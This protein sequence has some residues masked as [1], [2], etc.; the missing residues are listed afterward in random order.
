MLITK[1]MLFILFLSIINVIK[2]VF[3]FC[4]CFKYRKEYKI[5]NTRSILLWV[6]LS[7]ILTIIFKG[8]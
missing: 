7:Y 8:L 4:M 2:E 1:L 5:N 3:Y 6:S